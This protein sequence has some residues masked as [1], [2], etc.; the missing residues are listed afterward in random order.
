M[1][2]KNK[3]SKLIM[4][5][6]LGLGVLLL[7]FFGVKGYATEE[8]DFPELYEKAKQE[9]KVVFYEAVEINIAQNLANKFQEKYPGIKV[10]IYR[11][12]STGLMNKILMEARS[13]KY[14]YDVVH[15][16]V[17]LFNMLI[18]KKLIGKY[19]LSSDNFYPKGF[20]DPE[21]YWTACYI[22]PHPIVYNTNLVKRSE[23]PL[24][25]E[26]LLD[27]KWKGKLG[28]DNSKYPWPTVLLDFMGEEKGIKFLKA[29][30]GQKLDLRPGFTHMAQLIA[31]GEISVVVYNS[32]G[33]IEI[34]KKQ[35]A[36]IDWVR[37]KSPIPAALVVVGIGEYSPHPNAARLFYEFLFSRIGQ[38]IYI[39]DK[40]VVRS[41]IETPLIKEI[42]Q[43]DIRPN[44]PI[45]EAELQKIAGIVRS[46]F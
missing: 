7:L 43:L 26:G 5:L 45:P 32:V 6:M 28:F 21:G 12:G 24:T 9:G 34:L 8:K 13:G 10:E 31:A 42:K 30:A 35:G 18:L 36:P 23:V 22:N 19:K 25:W 15:V 37:M 2:A 38:E 27:Q 40:I 16:N 39:R 33:T 14:M 17:E 3:E 4:K 41:D 20:K 44:K 1:F 11:G 46:I 29:L